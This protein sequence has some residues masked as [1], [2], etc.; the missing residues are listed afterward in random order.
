MS[1][2]KATD[3]VF[4]REFSQNTADKLDLKLKIQKK[5]SQAKTAARILRIKKQKKRERKIKRAP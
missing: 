3:P 2:Q 5:K 1:N 4:R